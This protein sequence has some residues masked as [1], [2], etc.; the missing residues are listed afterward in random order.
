MVWLLRQTKS[1]SVVGINREMCI[2]V[3]DCVVGESIFDVRDFMFVDVYKNQ[4]KNYHNNF[5]SNRHPLNK[6]RYISDQC[7]LQYYNTQSNGLMGN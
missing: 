6:S 3:D 1:I 5:K 4:R 2:Y 7:I